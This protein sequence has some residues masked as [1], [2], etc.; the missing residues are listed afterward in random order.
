MASTKV[1]Y[2][3][4]PDRREEILEKMENMFGL[5]PSYNEDYIHMRGD[6][7]SG[8]ESVGMSLEKEVIKV[9]V[10]LEDDSLLEKFNAILGEPTRIKGRRR[11]PH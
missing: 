6:E 11:R 9:M 7:E 2:E 5:R 8:I 10:V 4:I 1:F 3:V